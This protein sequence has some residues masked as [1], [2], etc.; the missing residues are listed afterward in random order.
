MGLGGSEPEQSKDSRS[1]GKKTLYPITQV[2]Y[3]QSYPTITTSENQL[4]NNP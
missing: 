4:I 1:L 2:T 3:H